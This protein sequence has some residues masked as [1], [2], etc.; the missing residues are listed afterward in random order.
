MQVPI[1]EGQASVHN[2]TN[3]AHPSRSSCLDTSKARVESAFLNFLNAFMRIQL[4]VYM[5][6]YRGGYIWVFCKCI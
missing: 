4:C 1:S 2:C 6:V 5:Y 3:S